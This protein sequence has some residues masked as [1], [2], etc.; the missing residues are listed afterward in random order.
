MKHII[1]KIGFIFTL[2]FS[3]FFTTACTPEQE[4]LATGAVAGATIASYSHPYYY[5]NRPYY[6]HSGRYYYGGRYSNGYYYYNGRRFRN[7]HY[8]RDNYRYYNGRRYTAQSGRYGYYNN[9][10][11]T[12]RRYR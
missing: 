5:D 12:S 7:G 1:K 9:N 11:S 2:S 4:A 3:L 10:R 6:Y 8:Y